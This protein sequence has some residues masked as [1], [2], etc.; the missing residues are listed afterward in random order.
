MTIKLNHLPVIDWKLGMKL[1][2]NKKEVAEELLDLFI[3]KLPID[4][5]TIKALH[6]TINYSGLQKEIHKLH[7]ALC[8]CGAPRLKKLISHLETELKNNIMVDL[9]SLLDQLDNEVNLL[10]K[11]HALE[12]SE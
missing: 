7:G 2:G 3:K 12:Q 4:L 11:H 6:E 5:C 1:A 8:Y 10:L 9:P